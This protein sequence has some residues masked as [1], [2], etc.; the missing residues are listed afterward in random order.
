[1]QQVSV[2]PIELNIA[3]CRLILSAVA[4]FAIFVDP[5]ESIL[6]PQP[7]PHTSWFTID[8][9]TLAI[10]GAHLSYSTAVF[11]L[12]IR[13]R[14]S[15][16]QLGAVTLWADV[17]LGAAIAF[18]TEGASS[19]FYALFIFGVVVAGL[20]S[21]FERTLRVTIVSVALYMALIFISAP[22]MIN[23]YIMRPVYL[24]I[25]GYL[26]AYLAQ[27]RLHLESEIRLLAA[28]DQRSRI[29]RDLH[30]N[31][32]QALAGINLRLE[33]GREL[34]R[35]ERTQDGAR[36]LEELQRNVTSELDELRSYM[37]SLAGREDDWEPVGSRNEARFAVRAEFGGSSALVEHVLQILRE[38][39]QNVLRHA[40]ASSAEL[41]VGMADGV[42]SITIADDGVGFQDPEQLPWSIASRVRELGGEIRQVARQRGAQL[43]IR[44]PQE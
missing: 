31:W 33:T 23:F 1:M 4:L 42:V 20:R 29:A 32:A 36:E 26:I 5:T 34:L 41:Q 35:R 30:D 18:F 6:T 12:L 19:P 8:P 3:R 37:R 15:P 43:S 17:F 14:V 38:A 16:A 24:A 39:V 40:G 21:G 25:I 44:V 22:G 28:S 9:F 7:T 2:R 11:V 27:Q 13:H 10:L